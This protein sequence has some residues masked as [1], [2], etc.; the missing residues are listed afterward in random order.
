M[1]DQEYTTFPLCEYAF[2]ERST[3]AIY[4]L[5]WLIFHAFK[6]DNLSALKPSRLFAFDLK[7]IM[8]V[9]IILS[10]LLSVVYNAFLTK[11]V[12]DE[13]FIVADK[14][15]L[16]T[17]DEWT[18][19]HQQWEASLDYVLMVNFGMQTC[20][21]YLLQC[22][23]DYTSQA[24][25]RQPIMSSMEYR[26]YIVWS[27]VSAFGFPIIRLI[28]RNR[29]DLKDMVPLMFF[30]VQVLGV[31]ILQI[32]IYYR[33]KNLIETS[34]AV[35]NSTFIIA[36][37]R[38]FV[39]L[40]KILIGSLFMISISVLILCIDSLAGGPIKQS[41]FAV[42][43]LIAHY[44]FAQLITWI[45]LVL[46]VYPRKGFVGTGGNPEHLSSVQ[47]DSFQDVG[48]F[49]STPATQGSGAGLPRQSI[50]LSTDAYKTRYSV[51]PDVS[52]QP[53]TPVNIMSF[54]GNPLRRNLSVSK[55]GRTVYAETKTLGKVNGSEFVAVEKADP[56]LLASYYL[57]NDD[58]GHADRIQGE[59]M[60]VNGLSSA[61]TT[62]APQTKNVQPQPIQPFHKLQ[63]QINAQQG[64]QDPKSMQGSKSNVVNNSST[65]LPEQQSSHNNSN[66]SSPT[67]LLSVTA[68][69]SQPLR[70]ASPTHP[71]T[72]LRSL[73]F[74]SQTASPKRT[75]IQL[76]AARNSVISQTSHVGEYS[77]RMSS[78]STA[79]STRTILTRTTTPDT[80]NE[81]S[82]IRI[83]ASTVT[84]T[85]IQNAN[86]QEEDRIGRR[87]LIRDID[88][89][90]ND[91]DADTERYPTPGG[92]PG[93]YSSDEEIISEAN[94]SD[95]ET[96]GRSL[97]KANLESAIAGTG[98]GT[99]GRV[100][101]DKDSARNSVGQVS[102]AE[103]ELYWHAM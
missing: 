32:Q 55:D 1:S 4:I 12:Y 91:L 10:L 70:P 71:S 61:N 85:T 9:L 67:S 41:T 34:I 46:I 84:T 101:G 14:I 102:E 103:S 89:L 92:E 54:P 5:L 19:E 72:L 63:L 62:A 29:D 20:V 78:D 86:D 81:R 59:S 37:A 6:C 99:S 47:T 73:Q 18:P 88:N 51:S 17:R 44:C 97:R 57:A 77:R 40:I 56:S 53:Q 31:A 58:A 90:E 48:K 96:G 16:K 45:V 87:N 52:R 49:M 94:S 95:T 83:F 15:R 100:V 76:T 69:F 33:F 2:L 42:D 26:G 27:T 23:W 11:I 65:G 93:G 80:P 68:P 39:D 8:T 25:S 79:P 74:P 28:L 22:F 66:A 21:F 30:A 60:P 82:P 13:G 75:S 43:V 38:Y 35:K 3:H 24:I 64:R 7:S 36:K 98:L 50:S